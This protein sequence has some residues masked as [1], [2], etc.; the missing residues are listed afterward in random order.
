[1]T[2]RDATLA[3]RGAPSAP[4]ADGDR[5]PTATPPSRV[6]RT[7]AIL[8]RIIGVPDYDGYLA[9]MRAHHPECDVLSRDEF[10]AERMRD[11]YSKPGQRCC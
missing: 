7:L 5:S 10:L 3:S 9:H 1:M 6:A 4:H 11:K 8:R 2:V